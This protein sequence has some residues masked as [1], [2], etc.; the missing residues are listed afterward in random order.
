MVLNLNAVKKID[1]ENL[2][3][4]SY[5]AKHRHLKTKM[6]NNSSSTKYKINDMYIL[7]VKCFKKSKKLYLVF[8]NFF[9][10]ISI[11]TIFDMKI[12]TLFAILNFNDTFI[13]L[14]MF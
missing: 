6:L 13:T 2:K 14:T 3:L 10:F 5:N 11:L 1:I 12:C 9:C 4:W 8:K 7:F